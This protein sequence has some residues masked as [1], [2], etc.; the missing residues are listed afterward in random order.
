MATLVGGGDPNSKQAILIN[1]I[2]DS[3]ETFVSSF[4]KFIGVFDDDYAGGDFC[5][6]ITFGMYGTQMLQNIATHLY[7]QSLK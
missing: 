6:G 1:E 2:I 7:E 3:V 5:A 4:D